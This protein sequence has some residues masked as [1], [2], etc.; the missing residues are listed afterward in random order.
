MLLGFAWIFS[1]DRRN[2]NFRLIGWGLLIQ[3][4]FALI[5]FIFP[6]GVKLFSFINT[7]VVK[8]LESSSAGTEFL[9][10]RLALPP[11]KEGSLGFFL[12]FQGLPAIIFFSSL[13]ALLYH[14]GIMQKVT[15]IF[16]GVFSKYMNISGAESLAASSNIFVGV[17]SALTV[18]PYLKDMTRSE[19]CTLL[20][21]GMATVASN[22][23]AVYLFSLK[24]V[25]PGIAGHLVSASILS[26]PAAV[27]MSKILVPENGTPVTMGKKAVGYYEKK[28]TP[29][30]AVIEGSGT[31]L[32]LVFGIAALLIAFLGFVSLADLILGWFGDIAGGIFGLEF[33]WSLKGIFGF[34]FYPF[35]LIMGIPVHEAAEAAR[36]I[37]ARTIVTEV[38]AYQDLANAAVSGAVSNPRTMVITSYALCGFAHF[39]SVAIFTGG[40]SAAAPSR[41]SDITSVSFK[42]LLAST[43]GCLLT[44]SVAGV[45]YLSG[46]ATVLE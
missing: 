30:A 31:G 11:G 3:C 7:A 5:I 21:A 38:A 44:G 28:E 34:V 29:F 42:A 9:F 4:V 33:Q 8:I 23:L 2:M 17:E 46:A 26:A 45:F 37:G 41:V 25:F 20:T 14:F 27:I 10:G 39:A 12:A 16:T 36:I 32:Q 15:S 35:T 43:L 19:L 6:P 13:M 40:I 22:V 1:E 24:V 18:K